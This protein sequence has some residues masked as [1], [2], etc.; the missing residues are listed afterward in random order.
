MEKWAIAC[1][2]E[3]QVRGNNTN[4]FSEAAMRVLKDKIL[5]RTKS[6]CIPQLADYMST[7]LQEYYAQRL[8]DVAN[9]RLQNVVTSRYMPQD[10]LIKQQDIT[11]VKI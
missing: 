8:L 10:K 7:F 11:Q 9:G 2:H 6:F 5:E 1:R 4:N 3:L